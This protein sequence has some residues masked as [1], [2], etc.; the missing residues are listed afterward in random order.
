MFVSSGGEACGKEED[1]E[2]GNRGGL[3]EEGLREEDW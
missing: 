1:G 3:L 2:A